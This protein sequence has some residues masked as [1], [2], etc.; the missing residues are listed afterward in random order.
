[1]HD[2]GGTARITSRQFVDLLELA[3]VFGEGFTV[4]TAAERVLLSLTN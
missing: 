2:E 4:M 1:M 3:A